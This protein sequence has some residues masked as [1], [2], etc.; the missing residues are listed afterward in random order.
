MPFS[1]ISVR[2]PSGSASIS[3]IRQQS[4]IVRR[5]VAASYAW[6]N[7]TLSLSD[8]FWIHACWGQYLDG[9]TLSDDGAAHAMQ[10]GEPATRQSR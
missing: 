4:S 5:Y 8:V 9:E 10:Q 1:P 6:P 2:S 7:R 3:G